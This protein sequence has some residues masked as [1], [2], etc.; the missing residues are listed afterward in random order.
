VERAVE[1][2]S[3]RVEYPCAVCGA[4]N[5]IPRARLRDDP[6]CGRCHAKVFPRAPVVTTD[7][8]WKREVED[9][10]IPTLID[11]WA[12]WCGPCRVVAPVLEQLATERG[13]KLKV[14]KL[15]V[16]ENPR[17][18]ARFNV[19]SIP[20]LLLVRGPLP[21]DQVAGALSKEALETWLNRYI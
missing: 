2:D 9:A 1:V 16:D 20:T 18:S 5:R 7:A 19:R 10:P 8:T 12:P 4:I 15:N 6:T 11:F 21:V 3:D 17:T 14:A 13:G